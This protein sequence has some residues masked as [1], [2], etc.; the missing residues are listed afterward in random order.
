MSWNPVK[1]I[2]RWTIGKSKFG[3]KGA[4]P[5]NPFTHGAWTIRKVYRGVKRG[6]AMSN[7]AKTLLG[8]SRSG[9]IS[10]AGSYA[11]ASGDYYGPTGSIVGRY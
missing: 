10:S 4:S 3:F 5:L 9:S 7:Y 11:Y 8:G 6:R 1:Q 2:K